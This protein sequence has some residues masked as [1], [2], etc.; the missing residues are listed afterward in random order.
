MKSF[1][2]SPRK[3][4]LCHNCKNERKDPE[5]VGA[6]SRRDS[7]RTWAGLSGVPQGPLGARDG[8]LISVHCLA[9]GLV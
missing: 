9:S 4:Q 5:D 3:I 6:T 7:S 8:V 1:L 2:K